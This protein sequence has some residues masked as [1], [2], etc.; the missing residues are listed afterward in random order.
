LITKSSTN[1]VSDD[2]VT[3]QKPHPKIMGFP[4]GKPTRERNSATLENSS[5]VDLLKQRSETRRGFPCPIK[6][7]S[8]LFNPYLFNFTLYP[9]TSLTPLFF[10]RK[11]VNHFFTCQQLHH[12]RTSLNIPS[13]ISQA[14]K[15]NSDSTS[16]SLHYLRQTVFFPFI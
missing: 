7:R 15:N 3:F 4:R 1:R 5:A 14:L 11:F 6:N 10:S 16:L 8:H 2:K 12:L 9:R 13:A